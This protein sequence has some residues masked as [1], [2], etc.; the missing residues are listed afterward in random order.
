MLK[1]TAPCASGTWI[2]AASEP[3]HQ[4][5][6]RQPV[7][8]RQVIS[9]VQDFVIQEIGKSTDEYHATLAEISHASRNHMGSPNSEEEDHQ[10]GRN[11]TRRS[12]RLSIGMA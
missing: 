2:G 6:A 11:S 12:R 7:L 8:F 9:Q 10:H 3:A 5:A 4:P 1:C